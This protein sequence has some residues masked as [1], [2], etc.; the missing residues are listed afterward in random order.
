MHPF[1]VAMGPGFREGA[2]VTTFDNVDVY[3]LMCHLLGLHPAP[4]NGSLDAIR[5][6]LR[7][8]EGEEKTTVMTFGTCKCIGLQ[9]ILVKYCGGVFCFDLSLRC[10]HGAQKCPYV[11]LHHDMS[12]HVPDGH[13]HYIF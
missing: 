5:S 8:E 10:Y 11:T 9:F 1:F 12:L 3:P 6:L 2:E 4:N 7:V 13:F